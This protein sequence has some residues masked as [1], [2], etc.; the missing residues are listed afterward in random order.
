MADNAKIK[1][2]YGTKAKKNK[3]DNFLNVELAERSV[4]SPDYIDSPTHSSFF[5]ELKMS[6][7]CRGEAGRYDEDGEKPRNKLI[8]NFET[9][10]FLVLMSFMYPFAQNG[11]VEGV[12]IYLPLSNA[13]E[14]FN[15][16]DAGLCVALGVL[17][18]IPD[19]MI[20]PFLKT[21]RSRRCWHMMFLV[22]NQLGHA[23]LFL[24][25]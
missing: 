8:W 17:S 24:A 15:F 6:P 5:D 3:N 23:C 10:G 7:S 11:V 19:M 1:I 9:L 21:K 13:I 20:T 12:I 4:N 14:G 2:R 18:F 25:Y 16:S 22:C